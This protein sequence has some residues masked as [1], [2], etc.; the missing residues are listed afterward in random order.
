MSRLSKIQRIGAVIAVLTFLLGCFV[1]YQN[2]KAPA[3]QP[4]AAEMDAVSGIPYA[5]TEL[6]Y[7]ALSQEGMPYSLQICGV[8]APRED[9]QLDVYFT[10]DAGNEALLVLEV[11]EG[12]SDGELLGKT[13]F[14]KPNEYVKSVRL[15]RVP[16]AGTEI[17]YRVIGYEPETYMSVGSVSLGTKV[18]EYEPIEYFE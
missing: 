6:G 10:N 18:S 2:H 5:P 4:P 1:Y 17:T 15:D 12:G 11:H 16:E 9:G 3:F 14:L 13:G 8:C 7:S